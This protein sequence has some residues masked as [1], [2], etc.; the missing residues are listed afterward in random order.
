MGF[1]HGFECAA[2]S[3]GGGGSSDTQTPAQGLS[4]RA[5]RAQNTWLTLL[6]YLGSPRRTNGTR[7]ALTSRTPTRRISAT[8]TGDVQLRQDHD[9]FGLRSGPVRRAWEPRIR[10]STYQATGPLG[11]EEIPTQNGRMG[12][13]IGQGLAMFFGF[14]FLLSPCKSNLT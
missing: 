4:G 5:N 11:E 14:P 6:V 10:S 3:A 13:S 9:D 1:C 7:M 8:G 2:C 12:R